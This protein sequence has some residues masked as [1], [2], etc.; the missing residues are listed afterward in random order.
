M[1]TA[2]YFKDLKA[3]SINHSKFTHEYILS[4]KHRQ[5]S[6]QICFCLQFFTSLN[7]KVQRKTVATL[8]FVYTLSFAKIPPTVFIK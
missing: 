8:E 5:L 3:Y 4:A 1:W 2:L 6:L 7:R